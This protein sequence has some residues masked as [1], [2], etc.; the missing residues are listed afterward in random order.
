MAALE[1]FAGGGSTSVGAT[2]GSPAGGP[3][4]LMAACGASS[5]NG[6]SSAPGFD[7]DGEELADDPRRDEERARG[8]IGG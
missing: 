2:V 4:A 1:S 5:A 8:G 3:S 6:L 7:A